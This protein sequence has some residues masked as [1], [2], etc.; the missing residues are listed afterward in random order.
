[1][2]KGTQFP[3][4]LYS[5]K[6]LN[7]AS[8]PNTFCS[9]NGAAEYYGW[10]RFGTYKD[11]S[12]GHFRI[13]FDTGC[14][15]VWLPS[16]KLI[17]DTKHD[18]YDPKLSE[19]S[20]K[21]GTGKV[22]NINFGPWG[23]C[24]G[25]LWKDYLEPLDPAVPNCPPPNKLSQVFL[26]VD[27]EVGPSKY[28]KST[29]NQQPYQFKELVVDGFIGFGGRG[30]EPIKPLVPFMENM[31]TSGNLPQ[32]RAL[33]S[34]SLKQKGGELFLGGAPLFTPVDEVQQETYPVLNTSELPDAWVIGVRSIQV[35]KTVKEARSLIPK[36]DA[37]DDQYV[38][39]ACPDTGSSFL[40]FCTKDREALIDM[41]HPDLRASLDAEGFFTCSEE[42][43]AEIKQSCHSIFY[44]Y[45]DDGSNRF[46][47]I[48]P[49]KFI[50]TIRQA[51]GSGHVT[52]RPFFGVV[53]MDIPLNL[54]ILGTIA[55]TSDLVEYFIMDTRD[56]AARTVTYCYSSS[57]TATPAP[58]A[59][60]GSGKRKKKKQ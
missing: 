47:E 40:K 4:P 45:G 53:A 33:A 29:P 21:V 39:P 44:Q 59:N 17:E 30:T 11:S 16:S 27:H 20:Q 19:T 10:V 56:P 54:C 9:T 49:E 38:R 57:P 15:H 50:V 5:V 51:D 34:F 6:L 36:A 3:A 60:S 13:L 23:E 26:S 31:V 32:D 35:G 1:M 37:L 24:E 7:D 22:E 25:H 12:E 41:L 42:K 18:L 52:A 48:K 8:A 14:G 58:V 2:T 46:M 43:L 55:L 28:M